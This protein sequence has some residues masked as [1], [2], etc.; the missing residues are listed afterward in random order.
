VLKI[1]LKI[2]KYVQF[3]VSIYG[4]KWDNWFIFWRAVSFSCRTNSKRL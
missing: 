4:L 2:K 1:P 3:I